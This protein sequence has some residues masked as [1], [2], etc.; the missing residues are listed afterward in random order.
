MERSCTEHSRESAGLMRYDRRWGSGEPVIID[1]DI[2]LRSH[3]IRQ[4]T[5]D[6]ECIAKQGQTV[7]SASLAALVSESYRP[8]RSMCEALREES[9]H[10]ISSIGSH[11]FTQQLRQGELKGRA[12]GKAR[13]CEV[14]ASGVLCTILASVLVCVL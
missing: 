4:R 5:A 2:A 7:R 9:Q 12:T 14:Y 13:S 11:P 3:R 6:N 10:V 8:N 1:Y